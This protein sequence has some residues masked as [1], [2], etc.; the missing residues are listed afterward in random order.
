[1]NLN[2]IVAISAVRTPMGKFGGTLKNVASYDLGAVSIREA[3]KRASLN[4]NQ[5]DEVILGSCRQAGNG[6]NPARTASVRGG[7]DISIPVITLNMACPSGMKALVFASQAIRLGEAETV[8]IGG[9]DSMSTIPYLLKGARWD[10]F[11]MGN[12]V[13]EDGWSDSIDPLIGQGMGE[14]AENLYD[15]Y[16]IPREE[17][18][19]FAV[20]S[21]VKAAAAQKN[22]WFDEEIV[23]VEVPG[24]GKNPPIIFAQDETIRYEI[25]KEKMAKIPPAFRK[26]G[27]V[28]AG[29]SCGL[30]DGSTALVITHRAH[31]EKLGAKPL[32]SIVSYGQVAVAPSIMGEGPTYSIPIAL[33]NAK[34]NLNDM[35]L[36]E[37]NEA[38]AVQVLANEQVLKWDR[39]KLNVHGGAIALGHPT[40]I[41]GARII[42]T[43]Y[44]ALKK[45]DKTFGI[46]G[47]CGGGGVS[48]ATVI[49][50]EL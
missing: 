31:A 34:M 2:D 28:S 50:R 15:K 3:L 23:P 7:V 43:L 16:K 13:L 29:N 1:M 45:L 4:G 33:K 32:F 35:D 25:D 30:S 38:F 22:G 46:A 41:S 10:G 26:D 47:I 27:T 18:D 11:K 44:H 5:I 8:L 6:P 24:V 17:Q 48:I 20:S 14:T 12:K 37:V 42:V 36:I 39:N 21:H 40:G 9:F 49:K 19:E